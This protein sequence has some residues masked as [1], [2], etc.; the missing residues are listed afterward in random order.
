[1]QHVTKYATFYVQSE[2]NKLKK[3]QIDANQFQT[4]CLTKL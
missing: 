2:N 3:Q 4:F 1:M